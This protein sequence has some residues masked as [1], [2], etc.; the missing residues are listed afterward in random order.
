MEIQT[1]GQVLAQAAC[2]RIRR[3]RPS[4]DFASFASLFPSLVQ[5]K[6]LAHAV[7]LAK[8][9]GQVEYLEDLVMVL[10]A[11]GCPEMASTDSLERATLE[12]SVAAY[13]RLSHDTLRA[14]VCIRDCVESARSVALARPGATASPGQGGT[15]EFVATAGRS[16]Q[17]G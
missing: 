9:E 10:A 8:A 7:A 4:P 16:P 1:N 12:H 15:S 5:S 17:S 2:E 3:R 14:A 6:G 11:V 13:V